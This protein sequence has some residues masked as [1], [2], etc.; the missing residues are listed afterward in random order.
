MSFVNVNY[1]CSSKKI[2]LFLLNSRNKNN[3]AGCQKFYFSQMLSQKVVA[4]GTMRT[5]L[6]VKW[7]LQIKQIHVIP[8]IAAHI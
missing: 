5:D 8:S 4:E 3:F 1:S 2:L 6:E 7:D